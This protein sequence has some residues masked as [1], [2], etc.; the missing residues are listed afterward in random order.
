MG[1]TDAD[2]LNRPRVFMNP[3]AL[4][5]D[6]NV[7]QSFVDPRAAI[8]VIASVASPMKRGMRVSAENPLRFAMLRM[9]ER[10]IGNFFG[11]PLP[12]RAQPIQKTCQR[13]ALGI[14]LLQLQIKQSPK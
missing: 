11:E 7:G 13:L 5:T 8:V 9:R 12:P 14:P 1:R 2:G 3:H 6:G 10:T 4:F